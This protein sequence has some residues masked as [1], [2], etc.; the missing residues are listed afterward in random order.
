MAFWHFLHWTSHI[1]PRRKRCVPVRNAAVWKAL[2]RGVWVGWLRQGWEIRCG[3]RFPARRWCRSRGKKV[4]FILTW[5]F[6]WRVADRTVRHL[7]HTGR[8]L[9]LDLSVETLRKKNSIVQNSIWSFYSQINCPTL[10]ESC[11]FWIKHRRFFH[12]DWRARLPDM[13]HL[14]VSADDSWTCETLVLALSSLWKRCLIV[15]LQILNQVLKSFLEHS[16]HSFHCAP[17]S[18]CISQR[19]KSH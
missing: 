4:V 1:I 16:S 9:P 8:L 3:G 13:W 11:P 7:Y 12:A 2:Q 17:L 19:C 6:L 15:N 14:L 10:I 5:T 18:E